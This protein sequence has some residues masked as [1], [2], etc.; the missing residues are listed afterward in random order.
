MLKVIV[1][2]ADGFLGR[3]ITEKLLETGVI[4]YALVYPGNN[5]YEKCYEKRL[6]VKQLDVNQIMEHL[7]EYSGDIDLMYHFAWAGVKPE[8]RNNLDVQMVN[9]HM[10]LECLKFASQKGIKR[11]IMPGSTNEYLYYGRPINGNAVPSPSNAYGA[12][13]VAAKY[14]CADYARQNGIEF[15]YAICT[16]IYSADRKDN[17]VIYYTIDK[18]L[19]N[20]KPSLTKLEQ[21]WDY[22][23]VDDVVD[24]LIAI[25]ER[26]VAGKTYAIG[27]G[28]NWE[29]NN[30]I[31]IIHEMID[32]NLPLGIGEIPY[33]SDVMPSSCI[34]L[35]DLKQD[36][37]F[38]PRV[39]F[40]DGIS[41][42]IERV[43]KDLEM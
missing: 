39:D 26:G 11:V 38:V 1:T 15:I 27:H 43:K 3:K 20:E 35:T 12:V 18:L 10:A 23:Y 8:M 4:V 14:L 33:N 31:R 37:G 21:L 5:P 9:I 40:E 28:D 41:R 6:I 16:G 34:D 36:T 29:L 2:G 24:A 30:Y 25:G 7:D 22:V 17:N 19:H 13:K 32:S 42:V